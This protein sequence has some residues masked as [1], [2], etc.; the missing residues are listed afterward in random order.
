M[1][2]TPSLPSKYNEGTLRASLLVALADIEHQC[3]G[4]YVFIWQYDGQTT[5]ECSHKAAAGRFEV[6]ASERLFSRSYRFDYVLV[7]QG[8]IFYRGNKNRGMLVFSQGAHVNGDEIIFP[9]NIAVLTKPSAGD[10]DPANWMRQ[11][12][13]Q[14][15]GYLHLSAFTIPGTHNSAAVVG[16]VQP[17]PGYVFVPAVKLFALEM[18]ECQTASVAEQLR[19]GVRFLDLRTSGAD[20]RLRHGRVGLRHDLPHVLGV[21]S[22]FLDE[23][24]DETVLVRIKRD[25]QSLTGDRQEETEKTRRAVEDC[26]GRFARAYTDTTDPTLAACRGK[27]ILLGHAKGQKGIPLCYDRDGAPG[28]RWDYSDREVRWQAVQR[29]LQWIVGRSDNRDHRW[30]S[31]GCNSYHVPG[32]SYWGIY[33]ALINHSFLSP[34]QHADY[35]NWHLSNYL[36]H[37]LWERRHRLGV[38]KVDFVYPYLTK[39]LILTNFE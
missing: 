38:V 22:T 29:T 12:R 30:Y 11:L 17:L 33:K 24:P 7:T 1:E 37:H 19:M 32:G 28:I 34:K 2:H 10:L 4:Y 39:Q 9:P 5:P 35:T 18:A 23:H 6:S 15:P 25:M 20:L 13:Q 3:P 16:Q 27:M 36:T 14:H 8:R 21:I 26:L 31:I